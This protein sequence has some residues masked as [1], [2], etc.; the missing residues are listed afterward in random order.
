MNKD[1][2]EEELKKNNLKNT[3]HRIIMLSI[4]YKC[5]QPISADEIYKEVEKKGVSV[6]LST[7]YRSLEI[8]S[9]KN[10]I[11]KLTFEEDPRAYFIYNRNIHS[12]YL[13]CLGCKKIITLD[14]CPLE[15]YEEK[16]ENNTKF[17][18]SG[19]KLEI[20]GYCPECQSKMSVSN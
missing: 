17:S 15:G 9:E 20:Y 5:S 14:Y 12:H 1:I 11:K 18:I 10:I 2:F 13:I 16:L 6:N 8:L 3:K 19:H 4:L 7:V